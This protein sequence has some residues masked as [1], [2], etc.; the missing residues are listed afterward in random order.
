MP[1]F[2]CIAYFNETRGSRFERYVPGATLVASK[3]GP[4]DVEA[5]SHEE[6]ADKVWRMLNMDDRPNGKF[7]R[8]LS[9]GDVLVI[10][11]VGPDADTKR[12]AAESVGWREV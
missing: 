1:S 8:S 10:E 4:L 5:E 11:R 7:E 3:L 6:V 12:L 2:T 9:V